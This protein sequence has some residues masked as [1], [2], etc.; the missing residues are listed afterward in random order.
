MH[1]AGADSEF[2]GLHFRG[3][4]IAL[5]A[6]ADLL[7]ARGLGSATQVLLTGDSAGGVGAMNHADW[8]SGLIRQEALISSASLQEH[9][10]A[11]GVRLHV[12]LHARA[13]SH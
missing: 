3:K 2:G 8:L 5:A 9:A 12:F 10:I 11:R 1:A 7:A 6:A 13:A 4:R